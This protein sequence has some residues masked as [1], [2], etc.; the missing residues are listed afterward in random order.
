MKQKIEIIKFI[1][2][3]TYNILTNNYKFADPLLEKLFN[4]SNNKSP[5]KDNQKLKN[6]RGLAEGGP[7]KKDEPVIVG[8]EG[9][10]VFVPKSDGVII[11]NDDIEDYKTNS[12]I[13][14]HSR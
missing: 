10:E 13:F 5:V 4:Y 3:E 1:K 8:E 2:E 6:L 14:R 11:P 7:V 12:R 9:R